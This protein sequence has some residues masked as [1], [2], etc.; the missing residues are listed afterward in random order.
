[1]T[2]LSLRLQIYPHVES[3]PRRHKNKRSL[4]L[5]PAEV[6]LQII[7]YLSTSAHLSLRLA[8]RRY[9]A[10]SSQAPLIT[11]LWF[12]PYLED[13]KTFK[14]VCDHQFLGEQVTALTYD[15]TRFQK[16]SF[17]ELREFWPKPWRANREP[18][19]RDQKGKG[20]LD[21]HP[22]LWQYLE[23]VREAKSSGF[24]E[25]KAL[26]EGLRKLPS[27][28]TARLGF[29]F[30]KGWLVTHEERMSPLR[31]YSDVEWVSRY[32]DP[33]DAKITGEQMGILLD[34]ITQSGA[35]IEELELWQDCI[36][37]PL[38]AFNFK[39]R[40]DELAV[41]FSR[42]TRLTIRVSLASLENKRD[43]TAFR[44]LLALAVNLREL[45]LCINPS[46]RFRDSYQ[47]LVDHSTLARMRMLEFDDCPTL[48]STGRK[49]M[50]HRERE[51]P[52]T[53]W[54]FESPNLYRAASSETDVRI[55]GGLSFKIRKY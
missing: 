40:F 32:K 22:G 49:L 27:V 10:L 43:T 24:D 4:N 14:G 33:W 44:K 15:I 1:M 36:T 11:Q 20:W 35:H 45:H 37:V 6:V 48:L 52:G 51:Y 12:S 25:G 9:Y 39:K 50:C 7:S 31:M 41:L 28:K 53:A 2:N 46:V 29:A 13:R 5:L 55:A 38:S 26:T 19:T 3:R 17:K 16:F 42:L 47:E 34:A 21:N 8:S 23:V 54:I 18:Y 30:Q